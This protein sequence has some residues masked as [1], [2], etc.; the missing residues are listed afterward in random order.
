MTAKGDEDE[1]PLSQ[2]NLKIIILPR[3]G[4]APVIELAHEYAFR[5]KVN[6]I[7]KI[8]G[9]KGPKVAKPKKEMINLG[10][11][12]NVNPEKAKKEKKAA[13]AKK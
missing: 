13:A 10:G 8:K 11:S 3:E 2:Q 7:Q 9:G 1:D 5:E 6:K 12:G 4:D